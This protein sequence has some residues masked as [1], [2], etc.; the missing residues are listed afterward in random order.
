MIY[1]D[2]KGGAKEFNVYPKTGL[3][4]SKEYEPSAV[5]RDGQDAG[6]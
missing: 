1:V 5:E 3:L 4:E 2:K 6:P